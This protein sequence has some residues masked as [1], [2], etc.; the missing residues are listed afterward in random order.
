MPII[1]QNLCVHIIIFCPLQE[2]ISLYSGKGSLLTPFSYFRFLTFRYASQRNPYTRYYV[3]H[4]IAI[5]VDSKSYSFYF[6]SW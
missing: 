1:H 4:F 2:C 5:S 3:K 6:T